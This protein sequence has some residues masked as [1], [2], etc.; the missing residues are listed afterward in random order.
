MRTESGPLIKPIIPHEVAPTS[1]AAKTPEDGFVK[2]EPA[3]QMPA[4]NT[5]NPF[6]E[7]PSQETSDQNYMSHFSHLVGKADLQNRNGKIRKLEMR[8]L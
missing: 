5:D 6:A 7:K 4:V 1:Q 3:A 2:P 8:R